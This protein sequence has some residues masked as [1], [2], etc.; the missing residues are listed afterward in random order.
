MK[1]TSILDRI[2]FAAQ[3]GAFEIPLY[4]WNKTAKKLRKEGFALT[5]TTY[6]LSRELRKGEGHYLISW[7]NSHSTN[8]PDLDL[9]EL[10]NSLV[11]IKRKQELIVPFFTLKSKIAGI[12]FAQL[13][14]KISSNEIK[15]TKDEEKLLDTALQLMLCTYTPFTEANKMWLIADAN[16]KE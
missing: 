2:E 7:E 11:E 8:N 6:P 5:E 12:S 13:M 15:L 16:L 14:Q 10:I 4:V 3:Y 9:K 1:T